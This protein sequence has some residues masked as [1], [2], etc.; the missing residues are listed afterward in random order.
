[1]RNLATAL[2]VAA[3]HAALMMTSAAVGLPFL[4]M[5]STSLKTTQEAWTFPPR[6]LPRDP[7]W[8]NYAQAWATANLA[9]YLKNTLIV[10]GGICL[11]Q[12]ATAVLAAY[13]FA[14]LRFPGRHVLFLVVVATMLIPSQMTF[15]PSY[16]ILSKLKWLNTFK[17]L[18]IPSGV[19]AFGIFLLR[20]AFLQVP[21]DYLDAARMDGAG[22][23]RIIWHVLVPVSVPTLA[24]L[25]VFTFV[26]EYNNYFW[27]LIVTSSEEVRTI[28]LGLARFLQF[29]GSY[30]LKWPVIMAANTIALV[31]ILAVFLSAQ[32]F[33]V[34]GL[35]SGGLKE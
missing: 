10:A 6:W 2:G 16:L 9:H 30:G 18:I 15:V 34:K 14:L 17:G 24:T 35:F 28:A 22:H 31:P 26:F 11:L 8:I 4:W 1:M 23:L 32:R 5:V 12:L 27:P 3:R 33:Y 13:A 20:Q 21:R 19:S 29:E 7:Q 25:A